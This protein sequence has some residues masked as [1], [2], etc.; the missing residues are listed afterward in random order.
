MSSY[1]TLGVD[2]GLLGDNDIPADIHNVFGYP[3][4][5][6]RR[7]ELIKAL[8]DTAEAQGI[9][10]HWDHRLTD[11]EQTDGGVKAIFANGF[12]DSGAFLVGC[13]GLHSAT[14]KVLFG[15]EPITFLG[16]TQVRCTL[17]PI[18]DY[19]GRRDPPSQPVILDGRHQSYPERYGRP[20]TCNQLVRQ[21]GT[22]DGISD[23]QNP[24]LLGVCVS[25]R[26]TR[27]LLT[28]SKVLPFAEEKR[29]SH[30]VQ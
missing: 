3:M 1:S 24:H 22:H 25:G 23:I 21:W 11:I 5:G 8:I 9:P 29:E 18:Y 10:I 17:F 13:D 6:V 26:L 19:G 30:G 2:E 7:T 4:R 15:E 16:M 14:R 20:R 27:A 12:I 28:F